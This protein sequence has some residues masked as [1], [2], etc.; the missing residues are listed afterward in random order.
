MTWY[1]EQLH[2]DGSV[3]AR[4][5][6][7][8]NRC[9]IGRALDNDLVLDDAHVAAHHAELV[10]DDVGAAALVDLGTRNGIARQKGR[11]VERI[12]V[13]DEHPLRLGQALI[14]VR[15]SDWPVAPEQPLQTR[16]I[17]PWALLALAAVLAHGAW[18]VWLRDLGERSPP[19]LNILA[20]S[21]IALAVWSGLY[22]LLGRLIS[23]NERF[24]THLLIASC[25]YLIVV[26]VDWVL[27]ILAFASGWLWPMQISRY[28]MVLVVAL[29]VRMHL[30]VADPRHWPTLR[31]AVGVVAVGVALVPLAQLWISERRFTQ[32]Q[33]L[34]QIEHPALRLAAP[35]SVDRFSADAAR[36][37]ARA[38]AARKRD[39]ASD[40]NDYEDD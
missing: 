20:G 17:W 8:G 7:Q 38:D 12:E 5:A 19:Y 14:R 13:S 29:I 40:A 26:S 18:D 11:R 28:V 27:D 36:L 1:V 25:G 15:H 32:V 6:L 9:R 23:G 16:W 31:C 35:V 2:R 39:G 24:F 33:T 3:L 4:V 22:A 37:Q 34:G 10:V 21:A 30:R